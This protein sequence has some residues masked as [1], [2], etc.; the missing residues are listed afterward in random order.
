MGVVVEFRLQAVAG[1]THTVSAPVS[2]LRIR[3]SSLDHKTGDDPMKRGFRIETLSG[4][5]NKVFDMFWGI[6]REK[7]QSYIP[8]P[9]M[10]DCI[11]LSQ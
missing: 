1:A 5:V 3:V 6:F 9:C 7:P 4:Q 8:K 11:Y 2:V 10:N